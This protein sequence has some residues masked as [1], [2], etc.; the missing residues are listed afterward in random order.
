[1]AA[2]DET[3]VLE[4]R[5]T[6]DPRLAEVFRQRLGLK[7][8]RSPRKGELDREWSNAVE[9]RD[10]QKLLD[11]LLCGGLGRVEDKVRALGE[12]D[13]PRVPMVLQPALV[14]LGP[15]AR[16]PLMPVV[17]E[18]L[19]RSRDVGCRWYL[20]QF[21]E[22]EPERVAAAQAELAK[23]K[24]QSLANLSALINDHP[25]GEEELLEAVYRAPDDLSAREVYRDALLERGD[26]RGE[27][28]ALQLSP[29]AGSV[30][31]KRQADALRSRHQREWLR[32]LSLNESSMSHAKLEVFSRGFLHAVVADRVEGQEHLREWATVQHLFADRMRPNQ[33]ALLSLAASSKALRSLFWLDLESVAKLKSA[34][35]ERVGVWCF[36]DLERKHLAGLSGL[37]SL[38]LMPSSGF[39]RAAVP[40]K[41]LEEFCLYEEDLNWTAWRAE[42]LAEGAVL[43]RLSF[44]D[45]RRGCRTS[46][47]G[48]SAS[49]SSRTRNSSRPS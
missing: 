5:R 15:E 17:I 30:A 41:T 7:V 1:M 9:Q 43:K 25:R 29:D 33:P 3:L 35:L 16:E 4:W 18:V 24:V 2:T 14:A 34:R 13:D 19:G 6:R 11:L 40:W 42:A 20:E 28:I 10:F 8:R 27:F 39:K 38:W 48:S 31:S 12:L 36:G 37:R 32:P 45:P 23:V 26:P 21:E 47:A 46:R 49:A 44:L 22:E